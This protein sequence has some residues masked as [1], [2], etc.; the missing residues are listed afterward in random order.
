MISNNNFG[1]DP[2]GSSK[3]FEVKT[4]GNII[5]DNFLPSI[6]KCSIVSGNAESNNINN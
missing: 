6:A 4:S 5:S 1:I 2:V 3:G